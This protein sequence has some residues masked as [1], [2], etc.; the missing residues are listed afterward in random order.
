MVTIEQFLDLVDSYV[1]A[2]GLAEATVSTR[3]F[4]DGKRIEM[5]RSGRD[6][7]IRKV[8]EAVD[9]LAENW[10]KGARWPGA[11]AKPT[12]SQRRERT[13]S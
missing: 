2:T 7:G 9:W 11:I 4:N 6:V 12:P 8:E 10:P 5:L 3:L 13:A 1:S